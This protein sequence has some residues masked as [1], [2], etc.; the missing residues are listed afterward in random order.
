[1]KLSAFSV[2]LSV[3]KISYRKGRKDLRKGRKAED[4]KSAKSV[5]FTYATLL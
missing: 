1:V 5:T 2:Y 3:T 4:R